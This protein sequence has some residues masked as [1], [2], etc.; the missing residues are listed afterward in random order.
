MFSRS[1]F[2]GFAATALV[3]SACTR[4]DEEI[5]DTAIGDT[6]RIAD[7][8]AIAPSP[9][10]GDTAAAARTVHV[11]LD[12]WRVSPSET[13]LSPG[14]VTFHVMNEGDNEHALE[15][16]RGEDE[17]ATSRIR[18]GGTATVAVNLTPGSY[19]L[20]CPVSDARGHHR[21]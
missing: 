13:T 4:A 20:Y 8:A 1:V 11:V 3:L 15:V 7:T 16:E 2:A 5:A 21:E 19:T 18:P 17:W 14:P 9:A 6:L 12:E 10:A